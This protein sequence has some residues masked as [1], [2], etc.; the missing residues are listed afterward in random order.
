MLPNPASLAL[1]G[2]QLQNYQ[3]TAAIDPTTDLD[4]SAGN[5]AFNDVAMMTRTSPRAVV[6]FTWAGTGSP[7]IVSHFAMWGNTNA[8]VP[9]VARGGVGLGTMSWPSSV[10]DDMID[11]TKPGYIGAIALN[12]RSATGEC[13]SLTTRYGIQTNITSANVV[14]FAIF[15]AAGSLADPSSV[16]FILVAY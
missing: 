7:T 14:S 9:A 5:N 6:R 1:Y 3:G 4:A 16:D 15:N 11:P 13:K 2:G 10:S 12:L 8:V